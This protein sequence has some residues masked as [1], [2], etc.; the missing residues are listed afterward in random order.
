MPNMTCH[1]RID[2]MRRVISKGSCNVVLF[3]R[4]NVKSDTKVHVFD[5]RMIIFLATQVALHYT[6]S[7]GEWVIVS[8]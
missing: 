8:D 3:R 2:S 6:P 4:V 7:V 1:T 5:I